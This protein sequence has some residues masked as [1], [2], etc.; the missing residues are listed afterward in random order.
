MMYDVVIVGGGAA[1]FF[2]AIET[3]AQKPKLRVIILEKSSQLLAKVRVS[4]GGRCNVTHHC[5]EPTPLSKHYPRGQQALKQLFRKFQASDTVAWFAARGVT[6]KTEDDGRMFPVT[7]NSQTVI[8]CLMRAAEKSGVEIVT[9]CEVDGVKKKSGSFDVS[10]RNGKSFSGKRVLIAMGGHAKQE[11]YDWLT[12]TGIMVHSPI[13][14]LFT[15]NDP[16]KEFTQLMGVSVQHAE[17]K[18]TGTKFSSTGP[19]L[20]THWGLSGPAVIRL[21]SWAAQHLHDVHYKFTVLVNWTGD[22]TEQSLREIFKSKNKN[23]GAKKI[24]THPLFQIPQRLWEKLCAKADIAETLVWAEAPSKSIN[25]L[26]EFLIRCPFDISGKTTFKEEFV[27]CGG[28]DL[29]EIDLDTMESKKLPGVYFAG[30]VLNIDGETGGFNFQSA[31]TTAFVA[32][33]HIAHSSK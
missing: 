30:E 1:G 3:T 24:F 5:F 20:I 25:R 2:A 23:E 29:K 7:D 13:P 6:L 27:S 15:F 26:L 4:G 16:S 31:W 18:I 12:A 21:S 19:V 8:D 9:G 32:A 28:V 33:N 22:K 17:V 14:S 11:A 10:C